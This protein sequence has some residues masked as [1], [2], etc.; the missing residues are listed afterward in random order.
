MFPTV[1]QLDRLLKQCG[2]REACFIW[3]GIGLGFGQGDLA[4]VRTN[5]I[6]Q[7]GYDLRRGKTGL[8]RF[9]NTPSRVWAAIVSYL[10]HSPREGSQL[11]FETRKGHPLVH[12]NTNAVSLWWSKLRTRIG[13][14]PATLDGFYVLRHLGATEFGSRPG[15]SLSE[16]R[17]W[18]GHSAS[19]AIAD[20]YM[21]PV[22]PE[23]REVVEWTRTQLG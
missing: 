3:M 5:Q 11:L 2:P 16:M 6:D 12:G 21:R 23:D 20:R 17:R 10:A 22:S 7:R 18:L 15:A 4:A 14:S 9:G 8:E 13:E 1:D 19:S